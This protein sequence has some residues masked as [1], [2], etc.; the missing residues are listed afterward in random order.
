MD[1]DKQEK[2]L[3]VAV[4]A[5][6]AAACGWV[7][8]G[9]VGTCFLQP[10]GLLMNGLTTIITVSW[11]G[12]QLGM[13]SA[14]RKSARR[15]PGHSSARKNSSHQI[16]PQNHRKVKR[17]NT[18]FSLCPIREG[19]GNLY[20]RRKQ[21]ELAQSGIGLVRALLQKGSRK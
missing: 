12:Y 14:K 5:A 19:H 8:A 18:P 1:K 16:V 13:E 21:R 15:Q 11:Y 9:F 20:T 7:V 3:Q 2:V 10:W 4:T 6:E 17:D